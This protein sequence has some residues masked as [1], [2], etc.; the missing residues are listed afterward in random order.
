MAESVAPQRR[1]ASPRHGTA[2]A[3]IASQLP[4]DWIYWQVGNPLIGKGS[5]GR[6]GRCGCDLFC[7]QAEVVEEAFVQRPLDLERA[8]RVPVEHEDVGQVFA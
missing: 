6:R 1:S 7:A 3:W 8:G 5:P 2:H 4:C